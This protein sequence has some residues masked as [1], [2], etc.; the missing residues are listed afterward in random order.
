MPPSEDTI[1]KRV[2]ENVYVVFHPKKGVLTTVMYEERASD[3]AKE[4][5]KAWGGRAYIMCCD[6]IIRFDED[7]K[8]KRVWKLEQE[9]LV[10]EQE[11]L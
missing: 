5:I 8:F 2:L 9:N 7:L 6:K 1:E 11:M 4:M 10:I 3:K